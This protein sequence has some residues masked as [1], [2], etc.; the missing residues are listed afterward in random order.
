MLQRT[1]HT[2]RLNM[3]YLCEAPVYMTYFRILIPGVHVA[4]ETNIQ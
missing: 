2:I 3:F 1:T 4:F